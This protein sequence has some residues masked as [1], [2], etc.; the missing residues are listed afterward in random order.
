MYTLTWIEGRNLRS[1]AT[2][3][4]PALR[5]LYHAMH[6]SHRARAWKGN[7]LVFAGK[8]PFSLD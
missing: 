1:V 7:K 6:A 8:W 3:S 4:F 2:P 5:S